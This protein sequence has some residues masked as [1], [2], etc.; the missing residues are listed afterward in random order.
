MGTRGKGRLPPAP[1]REAIPA[2]RSVGLPAPPL[3]RIR[4]ALEAL[5]PSATA[6][7]D[8]R[9]ATPSAFSGRAVTYGP[10]TETL[11]AAALRHLDSV[12]KAIDE[13]DAHA[14][15]E[16]ALELAAL[17]AELEAAQVIKPLLVGL[18]RIEQLREFRGKQLEAAHAEHDQRRAWQAEL[19][20]TEPRMCR[21]SKL[22]QAKVLKQRYQIPQSV[23]QI[24][25][26]LDP[27]P[28]SK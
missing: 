1:T 24:R 26:Q 20:R 4:E 8:R 5:P 2:A 9:V 14:A 15:A 21:A 28:R 7:P 22:H 13:H 19:H 6:D 17:L 23:Q 12:E 27:R 18:D 11:I 10:T 16:R 3:Q 25:K